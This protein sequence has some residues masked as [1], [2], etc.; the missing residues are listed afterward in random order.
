MDE[1][2]LLGQHGRDKEDRAT[3][4][5]FY[6]DPRMVAHI[7][8]VAQN[9][10]RDIYHEMLTPLAADSVILDL[11]SSRYS[12]LPA[13]IPLAGVV[14][15][16]MN[17]AEMAANPQLTSAIVHDLNTDPRLPFATASFAAVLNAVSVQYIQH[18]EAIFRE[19]AR[20]LRPGGPFIVSF[21][22]RLFPT[23]AIRAWRERDDEG[24]ITLVMNYFALAGAFGLPTI[25]RRSGTPG[26]W[27]TPGTDP[28]YAVVGY[29]TP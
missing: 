28:I 23:K 19:V 20:V 18:P 1:A 29:K 12:H 26:T 15:L 9:A 22:N 25:V 7:D 27:R 5:Q 13:A 10:L 16:G 14:G 17:A 2:Q 21:S 3:D 24:H 6:R 4:D 11:M 8:T